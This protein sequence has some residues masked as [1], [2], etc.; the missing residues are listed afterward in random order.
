MYAAIGGI[1]LSYGLYQ[2]ANE[3]KAVLRQAALWAVD[4]QYVDRKWLPE[5]LDYLITFNEKIAKFSTRLSEERK[6][7]LAIL[8]SHYLRLLN[9]NQQST[10][11]RN[12]RQGIELL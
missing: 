9:E 4:Q 12:F 2:N 7:A 3:I 5:D 6:Q 10:Y 11:L 1:L 8:I